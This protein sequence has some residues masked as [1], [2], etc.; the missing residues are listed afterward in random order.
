MKGKQRIG[1]QAGWKRCQERGGKALYNPK[2]EIKI[3]KTVSR[4]QRRDSKS[5]ETEDLFSPK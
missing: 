4:G 1:D 5:L 3:A 2:Q